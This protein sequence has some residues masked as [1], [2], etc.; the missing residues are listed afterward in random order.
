MSVIKGIPRD[1]GPYQGKNIPI[2]GTESM[3]CLEPKENEEVRKVVAKGDGGS[4]RKPEWS[5]GS[6]GVR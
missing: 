1:V 4:L 3:R 2:A 5:V 6:W